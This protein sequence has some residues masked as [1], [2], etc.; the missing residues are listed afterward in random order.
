MSFL[1]LESFCYEWK[2]I[3]LI[4]I[5]F[6]LLLDTIYVYFSAQSHCDSGVCPGVKQDLK[7]PRQRCQV[8][9]NLT[10]PQLF[11]L[12]FISCHLFAFQKRFHLGEKMDVRSTRPGLYGEWS[13]IS[14]S[15][16]SNN[17][18]F[19]PAHGCVLS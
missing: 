5:V 15:N 6:M 14:Q 17:F 12:F 16:F 2:K 19:S 10:S 11:F 8:P 13:R 4:Q 18:V 1:K 7:F 3:S 9:V